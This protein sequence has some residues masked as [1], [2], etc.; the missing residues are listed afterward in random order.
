MESQESVT[1]KDVAVDFTQE[2]WALL[3]TSQ[4]KLFRDVMLENISHLVSVGNQLYKSDVISHLEQG[5]QL[6]R[7]ELGFLQGQSPGREDDLRKQEMISMQHI[8]KKDTSVISAMQRSHSQED[9]LECNDFREKFTEILTLTQ[10]VIPQVGKKPFFSQDF[11]K[12]ISY[13]SS[14][15]I[16][17]QIHARSKSYECHQRTNAFIQSSALRQHDNTQTGEKTFECHVCR[18]AFSK[19]SNLRRHEMIHTGVKPHGCHLCGKSFTHC[20]DLRKHERIHTGEKL[21]GCHLCGKAFSKSY[22]LRRHEMIHTREKP[23][24]CH[25]CGKAFTHCSDL[26]KHERTHFGEKPYG[27]HLCGKTFSKTS[28][29]R[30][31]ERTH[32]GEKPYECHLCGKAFTHCSHLR[33]HERTHTGE[34]P[35]ECHV[36]G[37]AFTESSVL[38]RHERTHTGEKPYE[39]H[40]CWKAFT[41]SSVLKRHE[42]THTGEKPYECHLCGKA[43]N[44]SS[45][46][47]RHERTHTEHYIKLSENIQLRT[48]YHHWK[49]RRKASYVNTSMQ[50]IHPEQMGVVGTKFSRQGLPRGSDRERETCGGTGPSSMKTRRMRLVLSQ[51][52]RSAESQGQGGRGILGLR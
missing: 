7:E 40:L 25:L 28:Y 33:K 38:R 30:Q 32:N 19:S 26:R 31:H 42:R 39:C 18:K 45:V 35:Y 3:D 20:S 5:E 1:F 14:F 24:E 36:C 6:S 44:H 13:L 16:H 17:K 23:N 37:K 46:L 8:Y 10:Y 34:K 12:A 43:F 29:L 49:S 15:N 41:D 11:G 47:R 50:C 2:E 21:Y 48:N 9:L 27:C 51:G 22:N 4:R 52:L